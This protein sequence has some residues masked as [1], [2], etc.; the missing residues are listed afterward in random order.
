MTAPQ[1]HVAAQERYRRELTK[2]Q[3]ADLLS[4]ISGENTDLVQFD[5]V[6]KRLR[7]RQR[8]EKGTHMV[9]LAKIVGSVGRYK[10]FNHEFLPRSGADKARWT[11]IDAAMNALE[12]LPPVELFKIGDAYF[13]RDGNHRV[14]VAGA[15]GNSHIEAYVTEY[16]TE[17]PITADDF[18]RDQWLIK[19]ERSD[20]ID[21]AKLDELRPDNQLEITEPGR[22]EILLRHIEAHQYLRNMDLDREG[23][24]HDLSWEEAVG[25]WYDMVYM[26]MVDAIRRYDLMSHF[27]GR[28]E[29]DLYL[30]ILHHRELIAQRY[31]LAPLSPDTAV[32]TFSEVHS[33]RPLEQTVKSL[34]FGLHRAFGLDERPLGM[35]DEE[36]EEARE[37]HDA[38]EISLGEAE[39]MARSSI[40]QPADE[41]DGGAHESDIDTD[42]QQP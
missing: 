26:P 17:I 5:T 40:A 30:W 19:A 20:F 37:R 22:F 28:T 41:D 13:V 2:A 16:P 29:A 34:K 32:S 38:G 25:S 9:P 12:G 4:H 21:R 10:D 3:M 6:A 42:P 33:G 11:S 39:E 15:N 23:I 8:V 31:G 7:T 18:E 35:S 24:H 36:Y 27:P 14:S 1:Q